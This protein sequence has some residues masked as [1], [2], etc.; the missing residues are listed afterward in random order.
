MN[1]GKHQGFSLIEVMIGFVLISFIVIMVSSVVTTGYVMS[2]KIYELPNA[3]YGAQDGVEREMDELSA[4]VKEKFRIQNEINNAPPGNVDSALYARLSAANA[5]LAGYPTQTVNLFGKNIEIYKF[6]VD[7]ESS[8]GALM[9]HAGVVNAETLD[10]L[11]PIIDKVTI[12]SRSTPG[13]DD[14]YFSAGSE[15]EC[16]VDYNVN[17]NY[18]LRKSELYQWYI[19]TGGFHIAEYASGAHLENDPRSAAAYTTFPNN[20]TLLAGE[21]R[22]SIQVK[23]SYY[24]QLL[25]C[26]VTPLSRN[27][28]MGQTK[29]SNP[30]YVSALPKLDQGN[31]RVYIDISSEEY[32][33]SPD[34]T[35]DPLSAVGNRPLATVQ[36]D[37][38]SSGRLVASLDGTP[39]DSVLA[40][41]P[42]RTGTYTRYLS[43]DGSTYI[44]S[45]N[46]WNNIINPNAFFVVR[47]NNAGDVD[48]VQVNNGISGGLVTNVR[49]TSRDTDT[50][51]QIVQVNLGQ[52]GAN[53]INGELRIGRTNVDI[54]EIIIVGN[55]SNAGLDSI[56]N[57]LRAKYCIN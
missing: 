20:Y 47:N 33:F 35:T 43:F 9:I 3:Y 51:W 22:S 24:G 30:I 8:G 2:H 16:S 11:V 25:V 44:S 38:V 26:A 12:R 46:L 27:G 6:D 15:V 1:N 48:F 17:K 5:K 21:T 50:R 28:A 34:P 31:Y 54:A 10:R 19:G 42:S 53:L 32:N 18:E 52:G 37:F 39:T 23:E 55:P 40:A 29:V 36:G 4:A 13:H 14:I 49:K 41:S 45:R 57:Y 56:W 7:Y